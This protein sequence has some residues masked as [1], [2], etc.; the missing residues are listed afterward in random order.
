MMCGG[1]GEDKAATEG[2]EIHEI[3]NSVK[4]FLLSKLIGSLIAYVELD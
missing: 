4:F 2:H 1:I 3:C